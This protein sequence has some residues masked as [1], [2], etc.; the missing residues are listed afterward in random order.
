[1]VLGA[2][3]F[4]QATIVIARTYAARRVFIEILLIGDDSFA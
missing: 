4:M 3:V 2:G 1:V